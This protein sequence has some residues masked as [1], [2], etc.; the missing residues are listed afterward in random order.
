M[1]QY[2]LVVLQ[3]LL[4]E[5]FQ[6]QTIVEVVKMYRQVDDKYPAKINL[7]KI[8]HK[9]SSSHKRSN[10]SKFLLVMRFII[11]ILLRVV[12]NKKKKS[13]IFCTVCD[14]KNKL[15]PQTIY[16]VIFDSDFPIMFKKKEKIYSRSCY[17]FPYPPLKIII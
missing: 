3:L 16:I 14:K 5:I 10:S 12:D 2:D 6:L 15:K 8:K 11:F 4:D 7:P 13:S 9:N 1:L 17:E